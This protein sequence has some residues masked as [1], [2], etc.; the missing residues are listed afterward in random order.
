MQLL[1]GVL[2]T[3]TQLTRG[4]GGEEGQ[5]QAVIDLAEDILSKVP[6]TYDVEDVS[7]KYPVMYDNS[8]N[9]VL[10]QV[11]LTIYRKSLNRFKPFTCWLPSA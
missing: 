8:M 5:D 9:T 3:Q 1:Q 4:S 7:K 6:D 11:I 10:R 2:L